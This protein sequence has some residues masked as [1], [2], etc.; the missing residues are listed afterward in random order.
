MLRQR[1]LREKVR[2][3]G[4]GLHSGAPIRMEVLPA[5]ANNGITFVRTD[6][7]PHAE[8]RASIEYLA[9]TQLATTLA[10]GI[11]GSRVSIST[12]EHLLAAFRGLGIDNAR[13]LLDGSEVPIMDGSSAP[14][15]DKFLSAG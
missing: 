12:V 6:K 11:N 9:D 7:S 8:L 15:V 13:V 2:F 1:T 4:I 5:P 14:F 10:A 3:D